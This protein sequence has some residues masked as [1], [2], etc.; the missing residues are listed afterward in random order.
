LFLGDSDCCAERSLPSKNH[1]SLNY[2][3]FDLETPRPVTSR[4]A[5]FPRSRARVSFLSFPSCTGTQGS[6]N[7]L[8]LRSFV[9]STTHTAERRLPQNGREASPCPFQ[10]PK[11][12]PLAQFARGRVPSAPPAPIVP[13]AVTPPFVKNCTLSREPE[14]TQRLG[15]CGAASGTALI[16]SRTCPASVQSI[17]I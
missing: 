15:F 4:P 2:Q 16:R 11:G 1:L 10:D 3:I 6:R 5:E 13:N 12:K 8:L 17:R 14:V 7:A 9:A